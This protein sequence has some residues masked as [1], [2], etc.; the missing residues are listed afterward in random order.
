[1]SNYSQLEPI[2]KE[3]VLAAYNAGTGYLQNLYN[4]NNEEVKFKS[5][6]QGSCYDKGQTVFDL[7]Y[8]DTNNGISVFIS[9]H[10]KY[11]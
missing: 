2:T 5:I 3:T 8:K 1:M 10:Y 11:G 7:Y 9:L 6:M 4:F